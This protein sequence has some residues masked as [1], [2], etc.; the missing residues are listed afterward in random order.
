LLEGI[1]NGSAAL[2]NS[3]AI[4]QRVKH[5]LT[6]DSEIPPLGTYPREMKT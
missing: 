1:L 5:R 2:K 6:Y 4:P 3:L